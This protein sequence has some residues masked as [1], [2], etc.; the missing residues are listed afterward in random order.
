MSTAA[1]PTGQGRQQSVGHRQE[2][3]EIDA[4]EAERIAGDFACAGQGLRQQACVGLSQGLT[5][6]G[7]DDFGATA[8]AFQLVMEM[9]EERA[10]D[11]RGQ[12]GGRD[13]D[14]DAD[15]C[16]CLQRGP[17]TQPCCDWRAV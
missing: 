15:D 16:S 4:L 6:Q 17:S 9:Q 13:A 12:Q 2:K 5:G 3:A 1:A 8:L 10:E 14:A 11:Q 7:G